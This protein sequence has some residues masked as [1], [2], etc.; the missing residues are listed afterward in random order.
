MSMAEGEYVQG[1]MDISAQRS[2]FNLFYNLTKWGSV[3]CVIAVVLLAVTRTNAP[4]CTKA[5]QAAAHLNA[6]GKLPKGA[7]GAAAE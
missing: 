6:C 3:L 1:T 2:T 7:E 5:D 4:D